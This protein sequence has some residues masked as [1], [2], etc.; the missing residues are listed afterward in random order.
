MAKRLTIVILLA[1]IACG[2]CGTTE[3][4]SRYQADLQS[5][6]TSQWA[7]YGA[8][9]A[10]WVGG[11]ALRITS[12]KGD[13]FV[14]TGMGQVDQ[15]IHFRAASTT[16]TFTAVSIMLLHQR[17]LLDIN[18]QITDTIPGST[19]TYVPNDSNYNIPYKN[20]ITIKLLLEHK[21]GVFDVGNNNIPT[22]EAVPYAGKRYTDYV[23]QDLGEADHTFT[24]DELVGVVAT[25]E[26]SDFAP[27]TRFHYS[28]TGYSILGKIIERVSGKSYWE[29]VGEN[30]LTPN[31]LSSTSLPH[32]GTDQN[33]PSP[34]TPGY[35]WSR[36]EYEDLT[37]EN[38][39][40]LMAEGNVISTPYDL[41]NWCKRWI[42]GTAGLNM[43]NVRMMMD[44]Q[45]TGEEHRFY[46][47]GCNY[48][49]GLGYGHNG[50]HP[51]Y[52][53]VMRYDPTQEVTVLIFC[54]IMNADNIYD[55]ADFMY[56]LGYK[57]KELLGYPTAEA[58]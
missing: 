46:G 10:N 52:V 13:F 38:V 53:T 57:A 25:C 42:T 22:T 29:F 3:F 54:S 44:V 33:L 31:L 43:E 24:F 20:Q 39:S 35:A 2:G 32:L 19:E 7:S 23:K 58:R 11:L 8:G 48:T 45:P 6:I 12:P 56:D 21:A 36:G 14:S 1:L 41:A 30:L 17:G 40:A 55:Q 9:K 51:N 27:G 50:G 37:V 18:D 28:N 5:L 15:N 4:S 34:Y 49:P 26:L 16:K 47:L